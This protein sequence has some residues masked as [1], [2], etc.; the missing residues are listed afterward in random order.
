V[1]DPER[2]AAMSEEKSMFERNMEMWQKWTTTYMDTMSQ[3]MER[4]MAQSEVFTKQVNQAVA[5]TVGA[6]FDAMLAAI[7][8]LEQQVEMLSSKV[9]EMMEKE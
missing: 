9:D 4:T 2:E 8:A 6:Q 7:R 5:T 3:A 1:R